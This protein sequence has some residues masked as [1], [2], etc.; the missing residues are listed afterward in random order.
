MR[1]G[2]YVSMAGRIPFP[3]LSTF[4]G[5]EKVAI[6]D[7]IREL[8]PPTYSD[9]PAVASRKAGEILKFAAGNAENDLVLACEGQ[10]VL[11]VGRVRGPYEYGSGLRFPA[12]APVEWL[13]LDPWQM[14]EQEGLRPLFTNWAGVRKTYLRSNKSFLSGINPFHLLFLSLQFQQSIPG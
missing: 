5:Q 2:G 4:I 11:G 1:D 3:D 14:P 10:R 9:N 7:R 6:K 13:L 12:Y 8:A